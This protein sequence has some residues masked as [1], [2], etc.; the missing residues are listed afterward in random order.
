MKTA[1]SSSFSIPFALPSGPQRS[2]PQVS[3]S[4]DSLPSG[5][6]NCIQSV[7]QGFSFTPLL[8]SALFMP[9]CLCPAGAFLLLLLQPLALSASFSWF[10]GSIQS[11]E[12]HAAPASAVPHQLQA[13]PRTSTIAC[14][15]DQELETGQHIIYIWGFLGFRNFMPEH[16]WPLKMYRKCSQFFFRLWLLSPPPAV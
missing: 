16:T 11:P 2:V 14:G 3:L 4:T 9:L 15:Q 7:S 12:G 6:E 1:W 10:L 13:L 8:P 5:L